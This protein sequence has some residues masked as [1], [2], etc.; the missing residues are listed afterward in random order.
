MPVPPAGMTGHPDTRR[1]NA[2]YGP[3]FAASFA[4]HPLAARALAMSLPS[5]PVLELASGPSGSAL[6]AAAA[7]RAV[8]AV[9][10]SDVALGLLAGE[11]ARRG[12]AGLI[13][14]VHADLAAWSPEPGRY[15]L[16]L[17]T[18]YW[19]S[20]VFGR[21]ARAVAAGGLLAWEGLTT[22]ARHARPGLPA[23][24]CLGPGEPATLLPS[25]FAV[26]DQR[27]PPGSEPGSRRAMLARNVAGE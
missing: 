22:A 3:G 12:L 9:D 10:C 7:G 8:T 11:A 17:C 24:W 1:W 27:D 14:L 25:G 5:G 19:D 20:T 18:G 4:A 15:A 13:T 2:R 26:L 6:A 23:A 21:A 16:V